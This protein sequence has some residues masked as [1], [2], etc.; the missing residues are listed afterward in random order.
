MRGPAYDRGFRQ[1]ISYVEMHRDGYHAVQNTKHHGCPRSL[2]A[3]VHGPVA[4]WRIS[5]RFHDER[6]PERFYRRDPFVRSQ[7]Q[8]LFQ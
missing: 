2:S 5:P 4:D 1:R 3:W 8:T 6:M 7:I